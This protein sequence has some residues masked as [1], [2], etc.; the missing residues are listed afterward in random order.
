MLMNHLNLNGM[1]PE[2]A[3][4]RLMHYAIVAQR[5]QEQTNPNTTTGTEVVG[6]QRPA[7]TQPTTK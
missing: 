3:K 5:E 1:A 4:P 7:Y 2:M 6:E